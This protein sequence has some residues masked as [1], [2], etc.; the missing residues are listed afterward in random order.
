[1]GPSVGFGRCARSLKRE[2][3][4][5]IAQAREKGHCINYEELEDG[6]VSVSVPVFKLS[7]FVKARENSYVLNG[8][9]R[10]WVPS[11][12]LQ[13]PFASYRRLGTDASSAFV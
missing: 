4:A 1:M 10:F 7:P 2:I 5:Q 12:V 9:T 13:A 11:R 8:C 3:L 6:L